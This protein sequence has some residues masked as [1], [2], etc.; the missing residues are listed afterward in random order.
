MRYYRSGLRYTVKNTAGEDYVKNYQLNSLTHELITNLE[1]RPQLNFGA[2]LNIAYNFLNSR[3]STDNI[4]INFKEDDN[5]RD[6]T[7]VRFQLNL[8]S[9]L[10]PDKS[11]DGIFARVGGFY[12]VGAKDFY[13]QILVGYA[14]N[15]SSFVNSFK[16][17][18]K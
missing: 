9:K 17:T 4:E 1:I 5:I 13:P 14:T 11:N 6:R 3:G 8:Y 15:L 2:D 7:S 16:K 10:N 18:T 12:H